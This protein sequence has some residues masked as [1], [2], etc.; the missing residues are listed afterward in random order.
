L[1]SQ[2]VVNES[3]LEGQIYSALKTDYTL[4]NALQLEVE[5]V[6]V[7]TVEYEKTVETEL[8]KLHE[9]LSSY[10]IVLTQQT[11]WQGS[12]QQL[13]VLENLYAQN[14]TTLLFDLGKLVKWESLNDPIVADDVIY[15]LDLF[16]EEPCEKIQY[17]Y[18]ESEGL[19]GS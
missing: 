8:I 10:F 9:G 18:Q 5:K 17:E 1:K 16:K 13:I 12:L 11:S 6:R 19:Y 7:A 3:L 4:Y 2:A 14:I 15:S